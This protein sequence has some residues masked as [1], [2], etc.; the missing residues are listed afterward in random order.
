MKEA[1]KQAKEAF[2]IGEVPIGAVIVKDN[3]LI[4][5]G[6]NK[7]EREQNAIDH[8]E[9]IA[10]KKACNTLNSWRLN[11]CELYVTVE[12]C[13]MCAGAIIQ[14]RISRV[15]FGTPDPKA[16][17]DLEIEQVLKNPNL[18]HRVELVS[19]IYKEESRELLRSFFKRLRNK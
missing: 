6:H 11:N 3:E 12:P 16:W 18:N 13:P 9:I 14:S 2:V 10:I 17:G 19:G 5:S 7:R 15:I 4:A 1:L 8:A